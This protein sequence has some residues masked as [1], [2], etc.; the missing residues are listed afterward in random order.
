MTR[1]CSYVLCNHRVQEL[2][3]AEGAF[4][5]GIDLTSVGNILGSSQPANTT[6]QT[7]LDCSLPLHR[8]IYF[9]ELDFNFSA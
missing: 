8:Q 5:H 4:V 7:T 1:P 2:L 6:H 9:I 3:A